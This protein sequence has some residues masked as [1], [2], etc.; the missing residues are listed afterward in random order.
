MAKLGSLSSNKEK[1]WELNYEYGSQFIQLLSGINNFWTAMNKLKSANE[2]YAEIK[3]N[4]SLSNEQAEKLLSQ[5]S[6]ARM[7]AGRSV[8]LAL[9]NIFN[10]FKSSTGASI[11]LVGDRLYDNINTM[12]TELA[13]D[14]FTTVGS[15]A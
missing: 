11:L 9:T 2:S 4:T 14:G 15:I 13:R 6:T 10:Q 8:F 12:N 7:E 1:L 5:A 3:N